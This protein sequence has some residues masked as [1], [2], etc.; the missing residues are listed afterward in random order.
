M[1]FSIVTPTFNS[2]EYLPCCI[3]SVRDQGRKGVEVEHIVQD[4]GSVNFDEFVA[5]Y[6][7][8]EEG[9]HYALQFYSEPD[10]GMYQ[11]I[12]RAMAKGTGDVLAW[13]N[14]DEQ[15]L[16]DALE[17]VGAY[18]EAHP[19]V[20]VI[21]GG[22]VTVSPLLELLCYR[23][24]VM[25]SSGYIKHCFL[26]V[27]SAALFIRR[28]VWE[29]GHELPENWKTISDAVWVTGLLESGYRCAVLPVALSSFVVDGNN[30]SATPQAFR[31]IEA[32]K[33]KTGSTSRGKAIFWS[34]CF[35]VKK[36]LRGAYVR[37]RMTVALYP[38]QDVAVRQ[39]YQGCINGIWK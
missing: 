18:F 8:K 10:S 22:A 14:S 29:Q 21:F 17:K 1:K 9:A 19:E 27:F 2:Q 4:G 30:L 23:M 11:A 36:L 5:S 38:R 12:N 39:I 33:Q 3:A 35:R 24:P 25:P 28:K 31:E 16:P 26:P 32:W 13:L 34:F 37:R 6:Q 7:G 15:Y 20:D